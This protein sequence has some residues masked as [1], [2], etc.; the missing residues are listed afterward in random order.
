MFNQPYF[1]PANAGMKDNPRINGSYRNQWPGVGKSF[2]SYNVSYDQFAE[3]IG[4][5][6]GFNIS[7]D[8]QGQGVFSGTRIN[9][10]YS[11]PVSVTKHLNV[12]LGFQ[13]GLT[14]NSTVVSGLLLPDDNPFMPGTSEQLTNQSSM[15]PDFSTGATFRYKEQ[16]EANICV[17]HL[18]VI[19][20]Q[21]TG[22]S[23]YFILPT[24]V[25]I[26]I[27]TQ[28]PAKMPAKQ[29]IAIFHTGIMTQVQ[30]SYVYLNYGGNISY[31]SFLVG[32]WLRNDLKFK[33]N[34]FIF[35]AGYS[36]EGLSLVYTYDLWVPKTNQQFNFFGSHEVTF[37]Y[38]F[39]YNDP[40][41]KM[42]ALKCP[43]F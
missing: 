9:I 39:K 43:I 40:K 42:R 30:Q 41:K 34:T 2:I 27:S 32:F 21:S 17:D 38:I 35:L 29:K 10:M 4:G 18:N 28:Y 12:N 20:R 8:I 31:S 16:Y 36:W 15:Y 13:A 24:R 23:N 22:Q 7:R 14:Q 33:I 1:N 5:G 37:E 6:I 25:S 19:K 26:E 11:Y 3:K